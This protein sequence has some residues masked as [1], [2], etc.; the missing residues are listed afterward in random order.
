MNA[1]VAFLSRMLAHFRANPLESALLFF[2]AFALGLTMVKTVAVALGGDRTQDLTFS[3]TTDELGRM[4]SAGGTA[5]VGRLVRGHLAVGNGIVTVDT[6]AAAADSTAEPAFATGGFVHDQIALYNDEAVRE[7]LLAAEFPGRAGRESFYGPS[8]LHTTSNDDGTR[9]LADR[10]SPYS[11]VIRSPYAEGTWREVRTSDWHTSAGLLGYDG[12]VALPNDAPA[13]SFQVRLN[14]HD[15]HV[16]RDTPA[17]PTYLLYCGSALAAATD[18]FYDFSFRMRPVATGG[19]FGTGA[20]YRQRSIWLNGHAVS[21]GE[22]R[23]TG[24]DVLDVRPLGP[25]VLSTA[26]WGTLASEQWINGR[27]SFANPRLG[28]LSFFAR[29]GRSVAPNASSALLSP[30]VLGFDGALAKDLDREAERFLVRNGHLLSRL[31][32]VI[33]DVRSGEVKAI[34]EPARRALDEPLVSF[35]PILVG[36]AVKPILAAAI[37][38]QRPDLADLRVH[39][40]GDTV[41][42][43]AGVPLM[44]SFANDPNG[45]VGE[46]DF[47]AFIR[48]SSNQYAAELVMRSLRADGFAPSGTPGTVVP[49]AVL[50]RSSLAA[51][52]A[53][54]FDVDAYAG[55]TPGR[56]ALYWNPDSA[57]AAAAEPMTTDRTLVPY[58]SRPWLLFPDS[59]GTRVDWIARYAF[60]GW[61]NRWTLLGL[62]Q[63]YARITTNRSVQVSFLHRVP[64]STPGYG[65]ARVAPHTAAAFAHVRTALQEVPVTGTASGLA[66]RLR[67]ATNDT[68]T[69]FAKT[70]TLNESA[71]GARLKSLVVA[72][73]RSETKD[74]TGPL[75]C[76]L[77]AVTYFEFSE[78]PAD[79]GPHQSLPRIHR[80]FAE[81]PLA[82]VLSRHWNRVSGCASPVGGST[83]HSLA[84][85]QTGASR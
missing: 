2:A 15:C 56:L 22:R 6:I 13:D 8:L 26:D 10:P 39:Y 42:S 79:H 18:R 72:I 63:A 19:G 12:D 54:V 61:E 82:G 70:G 7:A 68:V 29:A 47:T 17:S 25:V 76:G 69:V 83:R 67:A 16:R 21:F 80:D 35:E 75:A 14:G 49:R 58:E 78:P 3:G 66:G 27:R 4:L 81:G 71:A 74:P 62:A 46:I 37:L 50:E 30:L 57:S 32:V 52:L 9:A 77:V 40:A 51:G 41:S 60:G 1:R 38:S 64:A 53:Q 84:V 28:T 44:T 73:G 43:V 59:S 31:V 48:C 45:C 20:P 36:S 34:A 85:S 11:L 24:G 5:R 33:V 65:F 23:V 55:R